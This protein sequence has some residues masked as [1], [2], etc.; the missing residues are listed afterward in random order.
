MCKLYITDNTKQAKKVSELF[1]ATH[2][3]NTLGIQEMLDSMYKGEDHDWIISAKMIMHG[4]RFPENVEPMYLH[5]LRSPML[6]H[7]EMIQL[8]AR[9]P[10]NRQRI[11]AL[12]DQVKSCVLHQVPYEMIVEHD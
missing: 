7:D 10:F 12:N 4:I 2:V 11:P 8:R 3:Q 6:S 1:N 9:F 5:D